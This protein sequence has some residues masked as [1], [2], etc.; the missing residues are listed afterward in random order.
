VTAGHHRRAR[1]RRVGAALLVL[2][3]ALLTVPNASGPPAAPARLAPAQVLSRLERSGELSLPRDCGYS[4]PLPTDARRSLWLF[5]DTPVYRRV[6]ATGG[7]ATWV[8]EHFIG[9]STAAAGNFAAGLPTARAP[10][11]LSEIATPAVATG[12][13]P[14]TSAPPPAT[15]A[16]APFLPAPAGLVTLSGL[17]CYAGG[18]YPAAWISGLTRIPATPDLL[19]TFNDYCVLGGLGGFLPEGFGM[20]EYDPVTNTLSNEV[21]VFPGSTPG[22]PAG[23]TLLGSPVFSGPY[24]YLFGPTCTALAAG[25]CATG[26]VFEARVAAAPGEWADPLRYQWWSRGTF[27]H[28][29]SSAAAATSIITGARPSAVSVADYR[30]AGHHLVLVEQTDISGAF[31]VYE[32]REPA[33][34]W[35]RITAGRVRC[36][37]GSG[38][39]NFCRAIIGHPE[40]STQT[41]LVLSYFDPAAGARGH[42]MVAG[43]PW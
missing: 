19:I 30:A 20:V 16:P 2:I 28:W 21:T 38:Y 17:P 4:Q 11:L 7:R 25:R 42:V 8:L 39:A 35:K 6:K 41:Q 12:V 29:I 24:L 22:V 27:G 14:G 36:R 3:V 26:T 18:G 34:P 33:G 37:V 15:G 13:A 5:C 32:S 43:F 1:R 10:G 40:L 23:A 9:G 31:T